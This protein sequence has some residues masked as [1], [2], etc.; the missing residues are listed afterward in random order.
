MTY[1][2]NCALLFTKEYLA[3]IFVSQ[4]RSGMLYSV[5]GRS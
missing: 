2:L 4:K 5:S 3:F 1:L